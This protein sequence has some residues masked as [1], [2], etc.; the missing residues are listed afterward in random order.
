MTTYTIRE[1]NDRD[2]VPTGTSALVEGLGSHEEA[3]A[4]CEDESAAWRSSPHYIEGG[5]LARVIVEVDGDG[6]RVAGRFRG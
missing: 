3:V 2:Y 1:D 4:W 6:E 5:Y